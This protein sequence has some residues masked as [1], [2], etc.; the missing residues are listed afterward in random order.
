MSRILK[1]IVVGKDI[2]NVT[3]LVDRSLTDIL[4]KERKKMSVE[5][6]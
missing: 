1:A 6:G 5:I 4:V 2:V 3:T